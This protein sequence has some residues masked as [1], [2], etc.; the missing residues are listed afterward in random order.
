VQT[1]FRVSL[2]RQLADWFEEQVG[3]EVVRE[4]AESVANTLRTIATITESEQDLRDALAAALNVEHLT[5]QQPEVT[6][7]PE[8]SASA[9]ASAPSA[10]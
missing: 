2:L 7:Q 10:A 1:D 4:L 6:P 8:N 9:A 5:T 3:R